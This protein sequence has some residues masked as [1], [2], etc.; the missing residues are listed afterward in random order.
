MNPF[1]SN[2]ER[3]FLF[4]FLLKKVKNS[5]YFVKYLLNF[6]GDKMYN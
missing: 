3:F 1:Y 5:N 4:H 2:I 6:G